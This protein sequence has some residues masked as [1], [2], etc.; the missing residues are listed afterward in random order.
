MYITQS[1][2]K[3]TKGKPRKRARVR[4]SV[5]VRGRGDGFGES[6]K[7]PS[8]YAYV[9]VMSNASEKFQIDQSNTVGGVAQSTKCIGCT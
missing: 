1:L 7:I 5:C 3:T 9:Q 6:M 4:V 8:S 2:S